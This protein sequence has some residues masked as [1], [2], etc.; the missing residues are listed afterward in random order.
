[1]VGY[2]VSKI[3]F[4]GYGASAG[5]SGRVAGIKVVQVSGLRPVRATL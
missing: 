5:V 2:A 3:I 1:M 4:V